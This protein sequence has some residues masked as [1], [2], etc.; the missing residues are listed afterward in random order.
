M[1]GTDG[2]SLAER[3]FGT[4]GALIAPVNEPEATP[5]GSDRREAP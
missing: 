1:T 5:S 2:A 3:L 4:T